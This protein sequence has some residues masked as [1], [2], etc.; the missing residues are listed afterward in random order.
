MTSSI[1]LLIYLN[2]FSIGN[3]G[4]GLSDNILTLCSQIIHINP[5]NDLHQYVDSLNVSVATGMSMFNV[6][7]VISA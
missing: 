7:N 5:T 6:T 1:L 4:Y 3:E 2:Y